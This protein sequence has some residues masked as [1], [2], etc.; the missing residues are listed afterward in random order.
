MYLE[1]HCCEFQ[2]TN[3][4][5]ITFYKVISTLK[6]R[7][8]SQAPHFPCH[9]PVLKALFG[10]IKISHQSTAF[11]NN[12][13]RGIISNVAHSFVLW[14][15]DIFLVTWVRFQHYVWIP[16]YPAYVIMIV[17]D[18]MSPNLLG[19]QQTPCCL[20]F[21]HGVRIYTT[22]IAL[23]LLKNFVRGRSATH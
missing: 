12:H 21:Y 6:W 22:E 9:A 17:P 16:W 1:K 15:V 5:L 14:F 20:Y 23:Q 3:A 4:V 8:M 13:C 7:H 11:L 18:S 10:L 19:H 2:L